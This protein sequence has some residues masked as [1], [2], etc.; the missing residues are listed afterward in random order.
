MISA[1]EMTM[2]FNWVAE[3]MTVDRSDHDFK[4]LCKDSLSGLR[5][6]ETVYVFT[7]EQVRA[8]VRRAEFKIRVIR[9]NDYNGYALQKSDYTHEIAHSA[10]FT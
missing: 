5:K 4:R 10:R 7:S 6:G 8:I 1:R 2:T 9:L 3:S